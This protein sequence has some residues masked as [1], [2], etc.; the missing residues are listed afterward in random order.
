M[1][2]L[3]VQLYEM[4]LAVFIIWTLS[5]QELIGLL[6]YSVKYYTDQIIPAK[7]ALSLALSGLGM[8]NP[9]KIP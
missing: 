8:E 1:S 6:E 2:K 5:E 3:I 9:L 7:Y 4:R